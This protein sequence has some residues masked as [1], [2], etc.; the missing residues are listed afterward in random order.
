MTNPNK[1]IPLNSRRVD[2]LLLRALYP[3]RSG[4]SAHV[5]RLKHVAYFP[6]LGIAFNRVKKNSS[7]TCVSLLSYAETGLISHSIAAKGFTRHIDELGPCGVWALKTATRVVILRDPF[8]RLL[9]AFLDKF[10]SADYRQRFGDF[11]LNP[12]GFKKF[13]GFLED[14]GLS[15]NQHWGLQVE[16]VALPIGYYDIA[17]GFSGFPGN[18]LKS[19]SPL[20]PEINSLAPAILGRNSLTPAPTGAI[21]KLAGFY[22][23]RSIR[24]VTNLY[25]KDLA[26]PVINHEAKK[27]L[28]GL[29]LS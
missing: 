21:K 17:L 25:E 16:Q 22:D 6:S 28:S 14:G 13:L 4:F 23:K 26:L 19:I 7:S 5:R 29:R 20:V 2:R 27:V 10:R 12:E 24:L 9:S 1:A 8:S 11:E 15:A 3:P 18:F